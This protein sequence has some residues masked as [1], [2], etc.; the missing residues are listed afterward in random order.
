MNQAMP[1]TRLALAHVHLVRKEAASAVEVLQP[2]EAGLEKDPAAGSDQWLV[3]GQTYQRAGALTAAERVAPKA[4]KGP[5][6]QQ[7]LK[8]CRQDRRR[9]AVFKVEPAREVSYVE[10]MRMAQ[11]E[12][13]RS[14]LSKA[15]ALASD[16][17]KRFP[18]APGAALLGCLVEAKSSSL[19]RTQAACARASAMAP[20]LI[21]PH[22]WL[23]L[24]S[25]QQNHWP[26][27]RAELGKA[28]DL[29]ESGDYWWRVSSWYQQANDSK[30]LADLR[31]RY[32]AR[33]GRE[34]RAGR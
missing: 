9:L 26:E 20:E 10:A 14:R 13:E 30:A 21:D 7:L 11:G 29:D 34:L 31:E 25:L 4:G 24:V 2:M 22:Y 23:G 16:L 33:F 28:C 8:D 5:A 3:L 6:V 17:E 18:G 19:F 15:R 27:A 1:S 32:K 12:V